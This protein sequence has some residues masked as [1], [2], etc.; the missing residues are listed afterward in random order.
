[1][2]LGDELDSVLVKI[3]KSIEGSF[4]PYK[5]SGQSIKSRLNKLIGLNKEI[6]LNIQDT[7]EINSKLVVSINVNF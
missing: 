6:N 3:N 5:S 7:L 2:K 1:M 4:S